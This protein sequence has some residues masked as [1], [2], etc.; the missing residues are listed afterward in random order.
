MSNLKLRL[1]SPVVIAAITV[2]AA[3]GGMFT[4]K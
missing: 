3:H 1:Y 4:T 2:V